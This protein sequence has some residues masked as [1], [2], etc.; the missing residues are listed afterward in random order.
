MTRGGWAIAGSERA[1]QDIAQRSWE[2][3]GYSVV[4]EFPTPVGRID[5]L[6]YHPNGDLVLVEVKYEPSGVELHRALGQLV[7]YRAVSPAFQGATLLLVTSR[8]LSPA[9]AAVLRTVGVLVSAP[10]AD[11]DA[12]EAGDA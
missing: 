8:A 10:Q 4:R 5:L 12:E 11:E 1:L 2:A 9:W 7:A 6:G 3:Q